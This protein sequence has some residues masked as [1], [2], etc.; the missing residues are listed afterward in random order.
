MRVPT[1]NLRQSGAVLAA[2]LGL[3]ALACAGVISS[4]PAQAGHREAPRV[5]LQPGANVTDFY[6]FRSWTDPD[7]AVFILNV[8]GGQDPADGPVYFGFDDTVAYRIH[9][10]NDQDGRADDVVYEFRFQDEIRP[11]LGQFNFS[12]AYVGH[13]H[14]P[15]PELQGITA[16]DG[17][18]S[19]GIIWRQ[20]YTI[21]EIRGGRHTRLLP[22]KTLVSVPSNVGPTTMPDYEA[23]AAQGIYRDSG[24]GIRVFAGQRAETF[25]SDSG[26]LFDT[27]TLRRAPPALTPA[28]DA[29]DNVN[30]FGVNRYSGANVNSIV[31]EVP[32][33]RITRDWQGPQRTH[34]PLIG[35]YGS[36][37]RWVPPHFSWED[38]TS[39]REG[40]HGGW[41]QISRVGNAMVNTILI[42]MPF[43]DRY[44]ESSP[45]DDRQFVENFSNPSLTRPPA[46]FVFGIPVPPPPRTDLI[47]LFLKYPG[48]AVNGGSCGSPCA[49]LLRLNLKVPPTAPEKQS[50]LGALLGGDPAGIPNGRRPNDDAT[51]FTIRIIGGPALIG[52]RVGDGVNF[53]NGVPGAGVMDGPGYGTV[54]G[55][56]LDVTANGITKEFPYL[57]T[58]YDGVTYHHDH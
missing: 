43:K 47:S 52:G 21:T 14:I 33:S 57:P 22:N 30:P 11:A 40:V 48:Q 7:N 34:A 25:Y 37:S 49:D 24:T 42:D 32:I 15:I 50:R 54:R 10:D 4:D 45:Q 3:A 17:P 1:W 13:P 12:E 28:E 18:G 58:P 56:H 27:A 38:G 19:E 6:A 55:N 8:N 39:E 23:L 36:A 16:L 29:N 44:N 53:A 5:A 46:S 9:I 31:I 26:A 51:D 2:R 20:T 41:A 35:A